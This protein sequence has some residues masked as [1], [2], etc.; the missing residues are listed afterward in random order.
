MKRFEN[1]SLEEYWARRDKEYEQEGKKYKGQHCCLRLHN[2]VDETDPENSSPY[3]YK[4][5]FRSYYVASTRHWGWEELSFCPYCGTKLPKELS[6]EWF[7]I[8]E[9]EYG[10]DNP[11]GLDQEPKIPA[12]FLTDEWWKKRG[13]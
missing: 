2:A 10:L 8:L 1:E 6:D 12:E 3:S 9:D 4:P 11:V 13:L 7:D 5:K